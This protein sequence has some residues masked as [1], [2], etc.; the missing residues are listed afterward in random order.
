MQHSKRTMMEQLLLPQNSWKK[1]LPYIQSA[2]ER[3]SIGKSELGDDYKFL[4]DIGIFAEASD[5]LLTDTGRAFFE[6]VFIRCDGSDTEILQHLL[7]QY[8]ITVAL[9]QYLWGVKD[10]KIEQVL[11]VLKSTGFWSYSS[12]EPMT[13]FLDLL[14]QAGIISYSRKLRQ[15]KILISPDAPHVPKNVFIDPSRP[16]SNIL[17]IKRV[18]AECDGSILWFDK[19][20]QK[21]AFEWLWAIADAN[22]IKKI[23]VLSLDLGEANLNTEA[24]KSYQ[25]FKR[26]ML[27]KGIEVLWRVIDSKLLRD[28]HDRWIMDNKKYLRNVPN[29]NAI[30]SGQRSE[31]SKSENYSDVYPAF[32]NYWSKATDVVV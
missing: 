22:K 8:P 1:L 30:S 19:H 3:E 13:H 26:E 20:F 11:T 7:L 32:N 10:V 31:M 4:L 28:T 18:L 21:E 12:I 16:F 23:H 25:R 2:G 27:N 14:N 6:A 29:V 5:D 17:W 9:Q 15:V 24:K